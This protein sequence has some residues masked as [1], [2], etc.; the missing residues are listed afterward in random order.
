MESNRDEAVKCLGL[1]EKF[2]R[3][4]NFD[5]AERFILKSQKLF[6]TDKAKGKKKSKTIGYHSIGTTIL[7][8]QIS[9]SL[10]KGTV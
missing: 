2:L 10:G 1:A 6:P 8:T 3:E 5:K 7:K 4:G 9:R